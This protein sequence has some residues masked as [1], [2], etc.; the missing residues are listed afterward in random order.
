MSRR[1]A[2]KAAEREAARKQASERVAEE[3]EQRNAEG[4]ARVAERKQRR[5]TALAAAFNGTSRR[6]EARSMRMSRRALDRI[7]DGKRGP[8]LEQMSQFRQRHGIQFDVWDSIYVGR[9]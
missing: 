9:R 2:A 6:T 3:R 5:D 7:L 8:T 4:L 1:R